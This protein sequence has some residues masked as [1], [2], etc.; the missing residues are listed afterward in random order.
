M[1]RELLTKMHHDPLFNVNDINP[2]L[3]KKNKTLNT[4]KVSFNY[5]DSSKIINL[6]STSKF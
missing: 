3:Y 2:S 6:S 4:V 1:A 5:N